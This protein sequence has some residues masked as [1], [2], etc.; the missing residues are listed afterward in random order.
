ME[1]QLDG[2]LARLPAA[3]RDKLVGFAV[4]LNGKVASVDVFESARVLRRPVFLDQA[5]MAWSC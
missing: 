5:A 4:A 1:R 3:D 2:A